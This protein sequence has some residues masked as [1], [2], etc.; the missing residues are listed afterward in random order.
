MEIDLALSLGG[1]FGGLLVGLTGM[2]GGALLT[3]MLVFFFHVDA[4]AA[5][6]SDL[7]ASLVMKPIGGAVHYRNRTVRLDI[8]RWLCVG[9]VP[10]A[11]AGVSLLQFVDSANAESLIKKLLGVALLLTAITMLVRDR[12][13]REEPDGDDSLPTTVRVVPTVLLGLFGGAIVG[14]TSVGSGS[15]M[16]VVLSILYPRLPRHELVGTDLV[17]A[18][19]LVGAAAMGHIF[20]GDVRFGVTVS[21][22]IG[23][24]PGVYVGAKVSSRG[25]SKLVKRALPAVLILSGLKLTSII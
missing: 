24:I 11:L 21:L 7:V 25:A 17:Q 20:L 10:G 14:M 8:V 3:P 5:V 15:L 19:P 13:K 9:S 2:G 22:L 23:A 12:I 6:G 16:I 1:L 18:I 4:A